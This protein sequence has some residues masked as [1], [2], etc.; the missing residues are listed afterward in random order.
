ME[1][2]ELNNNEFNEQQAVSV[3]KE[4]RLNKYVILAVVGLVV[5]LSSIGLTAFTYVTANA[6]IIQQSTEIDELKNEVNTWKTNYGQ[7]SYKLT[8]LA[9][10]YELS[11]F[12]HRAEGGAVTDDFVVNKLDFYYDGKTTLKGIIDID[13]QPDMALAYKGK[14]SFSLPDRELK[15]KVED[16]ARV[17]ATQYNKYF[18]NMNFPKWDDGEYSITIKNYEVGSLTKGGFKLKGE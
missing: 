6:K 9:T 7:V 10:D 13:T 3:K 2:A 5:L 18:E 11:R 17:V 12:Q 14:G 4:A 15:G 1:I 16:I 8:T